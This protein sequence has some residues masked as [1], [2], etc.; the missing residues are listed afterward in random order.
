MAIVE[1][2][3]LPAGSYRRRGEQFEGLP[4]KNRSSGVR[5]PVP[6]AQVPVIRFFQ[7]VPEEN[8]VGFRLHSTGRKRDTQL[9]RCEGLGRRSLR[10]KME[11]YPRQIVLMKVLRPEPQV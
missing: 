11:P 10:V 1:S 6:Q 7:A 2:R 9:R 4:M 5:G 8:L 3:T